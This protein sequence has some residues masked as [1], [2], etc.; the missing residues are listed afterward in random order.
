MNTSPACFIVP[1]TATVAEPEPE[2]GPNGG[3]QPPKNISPS[4]LN[5]RAWVDALTAGPPPVHPDP[6]RWSPV[7]PRTN[8]SEPPSGTAQPRPPSLYMRKS[9]VKNV[10]I[11]P[12]FGPGW[13]SPLPEPEPLPLP[14]PEPWPS[15]T[16][17]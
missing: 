14:L 1:V 12:A 10:D 13:T 11:P 2:P 8:P 7:P 6:T 17:C 3:K 5:V 4:P 16:V 9:G 15:G